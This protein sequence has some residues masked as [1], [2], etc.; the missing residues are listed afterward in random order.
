MITVFRSELDKYVN[1]TARKKVQKFQLI[2][3]FFQNSILIS[4]DFEVGNEYKR[5]ILA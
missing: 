5:K 1:K 3:K 4:E 2:S